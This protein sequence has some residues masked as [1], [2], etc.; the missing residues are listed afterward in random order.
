M[1]TVT[2]ESLIADQAWTLVSQHLQNRNDLLTDGILF[3]ESHPVDRPHAGQLV[4]L[5]YHLRSTLRKLIEETA[6]FIPLAAPD[7]QIRRQWM[8]V[9]QLNYL[10][11]QVDSEIRGI[12]RQSR[13]FKHWRDE[14]MMRRRPRT[15]SKAQH[16]N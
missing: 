8:V 11:C 6:T 15:Q 2:Y 3:L 5:Q 4:V 14:R 1:Q 9:H 10:L 16:L 7:Q 13:D 12:A